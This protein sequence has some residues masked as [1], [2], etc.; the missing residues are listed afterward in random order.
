MENTIPINTKVVEE[1]WLEP[2]IIQDTH[3]SLATTLRDYKED[4][5]LMEL[6]HNRCDDL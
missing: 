4:V 6:S 5:R 1:F 3:K 2:L